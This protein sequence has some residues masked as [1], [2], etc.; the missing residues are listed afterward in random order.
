LPY[1]EGTKDHFDVYIKSPELVVILVLHTVPELRNAPPILRERKQLLLWTDSPPMQHLDLVDLGTRRVSQIV[2][3]NDDLK[4][5]RLSRDGRWRSSVAKVGTNQ[6]QAFVRSVS[7]AKSL[8]SSAWL[9]VTPASDRFFYAFWSAKG[10]LIY[11]LSSHSAGG[12][13]RFLD[14]VRLDPESKHPVGE[15]MSI[16]EFDEGLVPEWTPYGITS[17][18]RVTESS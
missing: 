1:G 7:A 3:A 5:P 16:Y 17:P 2:W 18:W 4:A 13:L 11:T 6:W 12:N 10:D 9:P 14:A 15:A 8:G